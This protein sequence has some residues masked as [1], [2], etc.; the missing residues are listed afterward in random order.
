ME[1]IN[2]D[3]LGLSE[4][5]DLLKE[6]KLYRDLKTQL[7]NRWEKT[8]KKIKNWEKT[9]VVE[10]FPAISKELAFD[11]SKKIFKNV[12]NLDVEQKDLKMEENAEIKWWIR[13]DM[14]DKGIDLSYLKIE[15]ELS[16]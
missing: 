1:T 16:K 3:N 6:V 2:I 15:R 11:E 12:F 5:K 13:I 14:D 8:Y 10:Y 7:W 9:L 4:L